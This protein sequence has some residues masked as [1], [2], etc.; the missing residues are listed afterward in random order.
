MKRSPLLIALVSCVT[1]C[2]DLD[3]GAPL[4]VEVR[5]DDGSRPETYRAV[6]A[7]AGGEIA[8]LTCPASMAQ[9]PLACAATGV[10][11]ER[12]ALPGTLTLKVRGHGFTSVELA[13]EPEGAP[14]VTLGPLD[15]FEISAL[16]ATGFGA[17]EAT[18]AFDEL[19]VAAATELGETRSLKFYIE[20]LNGAPQVYFQNT[21][22]FPRH[23][24]FVQTGLGR[25][26][27]AAAFEAS[28]RGP[29][30]TAMVGTLISRPA[31]S[32]PGNAEHERLTAPVT[33]EF[34]PSDDLSPE[35]ALG[36]HRL[37]EERLGFLALDGGDSRLAYVPA[38]ARAESELDG[39]RGR[40]HASEA[41]F[42]RTS[43]LYAGVREQILNPGLSFG[44]LRLFSPEELA[45]NVVSRRD[46]LVLTRLPNDLPLVGGTITE[47][48]QTP[49]AH[50]NLAA[51]A[52]GTPNIALAAASSDPRVAPL[53]GELVRFEV[54][55]GS[56][57]LE[58]ATLAQAD[59]FWQSQ[60]RDPLVPES[61][62]EFSG[63]PSFDELAFEDALRVGA[64]AANIA[65][66]HRLLGDAAP[67][68]FAVPFSAFDSFM[69]E[70]RVTEGGCQA[71]LAACTADGRDGSICEGAA[72]PC[73]S[74]AAASDDF[75]AYLERL[76]ADDDVR[77]DT[78]LREASLHGLRHLIENTELD[79]TLAE[80]L[81]ARV[82]EIFGD[83][84]VRLRSST[85]VEDLAE[86]SGAGLYD[87][88]SAEA[89]GERRASSRIR[90]V[91]A[92]TYTFAAFE[93]RAA[94][95]V[96][97]SAVRMG[98][99][100]NQAFG[101]ELAN[102]VLVTRNIPSP[103]SP[104]FYVNV[105]LGE[106]PVA[107]PE[108]GAVPEILTLVPVAEERW[109]TVRQRFSSLSPETPILSDEE[110]VRLAEAAAR[111]QAHFAPLYGTSLQ[112]MAL[113]LEFKLV[114]PERALVI[115]QA[116]PYFSREP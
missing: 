53:L 1:A 48:L 69:R 61:D 46:I 5:A 64:K 56:F 109:E 72:G 99:A 84:S 23:I 30:R 50:V 41:V 112:Q 113:D 9:G 74:A 32:I 40:F 76:L 67:Y 54:A 7:S 62:L 96:T 88:V 26:I 78:A 87:S 37:L 110:S 101:D 71:A 22:R 116:R 91:W 49:L 13:G 86:F 11:L 51:R 89:A 24:D 58:P 34:F 103:G 6:Y 4:V 42:A 66:L 39:E 2:G 104:G 97:E 31:L 21:K 107:N 85:N 38:S 111:A 105:Q 29:E 106:L 114:A 57:S 115:K 102:G 81:D 83:A 3:P 17:D 100:V 45:Q 93:E 65:E 70:S 27:P 15:A 52:R 59:A 75:F 20:N 16:Y 98:V 77:S 108:N 14:S 43:E 73:L 18:L 94:W 35:Q 36:A 90:R 55:G 95:N 25:A 12:A 63:L 10:R 19:A 80:T 8:A 68:G 44:T 60:L 33:L 82:A 92:S 79:A 28:V 47:E